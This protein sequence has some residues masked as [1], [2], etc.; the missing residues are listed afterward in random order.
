MFTIF[1]KLLFLKIVFYEN[2]YFTKKY[3][4]YVLCF[5]YIVH[6]YQFWPNLVRQTQPDKL[7]YFSKKDWKS[8]AI[9]KYASVYTFITREQHSPQTLSTKFT[10]CSPLCNLICVHIPIFGRYTWYLMFYNRKTTENLGK[11]G[12]FPQG[13]LPGERTSFLQKWQK[14]LCNI[15]LHPVA[16]I[17]RKV[18]KFPK[19]FFGQVTTLFTHEDQWAHISSFLYTTPVTWW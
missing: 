3:V 18:T 17:Y 2:M 16:I 10:P 12:H 19:K 8:H 11:M 14:I 1:L 6:F 4:V 5:L 7:G 9:S 13:D 15:N